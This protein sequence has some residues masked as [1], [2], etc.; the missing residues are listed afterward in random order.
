[1][2]TKYKKY[3]VAIIGGG[4]GGLLTA[5]EI[6]EKCPSQKIVLFEGGKPLLERQCPMIAHKSDKC[7]CCKPCA[8]MNGMAGAGAFSDG[9]YILGTEYGGWLTDFVDK[10]IAQKYINLANTIL[11]KFGATKEIYNPSNELKGLCEKFDLQMLQTKLKHLGTDEN[12][13]TMLKLIEYLGTKIEIQTLTTVNDVNIET[14]TLTFTKANEK[15]NITAENIVFA[16][17]RVGSQMFSDWCKKNKISLTSNQVDLGVR[18][19]LPRRV[20]KSFAEKIYEPKIIYKSKGYGDLTRMF[21]FNDGGQVIVE[22]TDGIFTVNGHAY[23]N[24]DRKTE[25]SNFALL[26]TVVFTEPFNEPIQYAKQVAKLCNTIGGGSVLVQRFGDLVRGR[27]STKERMQQCE[28]KPSLK[29]IAGDLSLCIPKRQLDNIIETI[30]ALDKIAPGT[31]SDDTLL[32]GIECK[33]YS[34]RPNLNNFE[35]V[36][37]NNIFAVGDG[38]GITRSLSQ[39]GANGLIVADIICGKF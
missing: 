27:R 15:D 6:A 21:C 17:G 24:E 38:V 26:S 8:I 2:I 22:N 33:Y 9:K 25:N 16:V 5:Y 39:A 18:V 3:D 19:E 12:F 11:E 10:E 7:L 1:M 14:H 35:I 32:Y 20:W 13:S 36:G 34:A 28:T 31:A 4:I 30:Y 37:T 29:T 23:R